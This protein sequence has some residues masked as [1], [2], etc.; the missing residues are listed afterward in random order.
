[1]DTADE[2]CMKMTHCPCTHK[3]F[4][5]KSLVPISINYRALY[6]TVH[7]YNADERPRGLMA[8]MLRH[9][10]SLKQS[11]CQLLEQKK[12]QEKSSKTCSNHPVIFVFEMSDIA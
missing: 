12:K 5:V 2:C 1:M 6:A 4:I 9:T 10:T 8:L 3:I 11:M 7:K